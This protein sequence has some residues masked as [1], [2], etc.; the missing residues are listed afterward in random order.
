MNQLGK[1]VGSA[2][3]NSYIAEIKMVEQLVEG[4]R[5]KLY[6]DRGYI[7]E[8]LKTKLKEQNIDLITCHQ[9]NMKAIHLSAED[10]HHLKQRNKIE[11]LFSLL[12]RNAYQL[13]HQNKPM[14]KIGYIGLS[15]IPVN[16]IE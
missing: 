3:S 16:Y 1:I 10:E 4:L 15:W 9:K 5:V 6:A 8:K 14:S 2:L 13:C 11:T 12:K 7:S